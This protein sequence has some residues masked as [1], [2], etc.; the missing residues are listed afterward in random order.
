MDYSNKI[1]LKSYKTSKSLNKH[2][3]DEGVKEILSVTFALDILEYFATAGMPKGVTELSDALGVNKT[4]VYR[5][6]RTLVSRGYLEQ[7]GGSEKYRVTNRL[8]LLGQAMS[9]QFELLSEAR[10]VMPWLRDRVEQT[11]TVGEIVEEGVLILDML[12]TPSLFEISVKPGAVLGFHSSAQGKVALAFGSTHLLENV[13][14]KKLKKM[15]TRTITNKAILVQQISEIRKQGWAV[16]PDETLMGINALAV[17]VFDSKGSLAGTIAIVGSSQ[18]VKEKPVTEQL[19]A[20][21]EA[22]SQISRQ[23]K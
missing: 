13:L 12:R 15:T 17:P 19:V 2:E 8:F 22:V 18:F 16:A 4:R 9:D 11:I 10:R 6:L 20:I 3:R 23:L 21:R 14:T 7:E 1:I 5:H